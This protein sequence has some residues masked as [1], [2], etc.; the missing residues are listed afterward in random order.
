MRMICALLVVMLAGCPDASSLTVTNGTTSDDVVYIAFGADSAIT[1]WPACPTTGYLNCSFPLAAGQSQV[2]PLSGYLNATMA[3][4]SAVGCG[5]TKA[6]LNVNNPNWYDVVD[7]SL[8]DGY[9]N[10]ISITLDGKTLGPPV[11]M[12]GNESVYGVYPLGCDICVARQNPPCGIPMGTDGCKTGGQYDP[13]VPCQYQGPTKGSGS[14]VT[15]THT[16]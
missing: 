3:F 10:N 15:V 8:V 1:S 4:N 16:S 2:F 12:T 9:S 13:T 14:S 6:E 5:V 11:G 7:V